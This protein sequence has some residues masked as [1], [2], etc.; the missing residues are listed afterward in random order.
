[1]KKRLLAAAVLLVA[2]GIAIAAWLHF[3]GNED[4]N[5]LEL[6]GNVD[7][8]QVSLAFDATGRI[9]QMNAQEGDRVTAG[10]VLGRLDTTTLALQAR[11][12]EARIE[13]QRQSTLRLR[14]GARPEEIAQARARLAAAE[15]DAAR[16]S[17]EAARLQDVAARTSSRGVS[18]QELEAART[19]ARTA[20]ARAQEQREA[21]RLLEVGSRSEDVGAAE[22]QLRGLRAELDLLRHQ[23]AQGELRAPVS[24]VVRSRLM[25][26]GDLAS[27]Q[28]PA[29]AIALT[30]PKWVRVYVNETK[31]G[32]VKPGAPAQVVTDSQPQRPIAGKV[33]YISSVAEFTPKSVQTQE[34]RTTLVYEVRVRVDD[35]DNVLRLG[36]PATVRLDVRPAEPAR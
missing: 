27:P 31:L 36:Q 29:Y 23:M 17:D 20:A 7:I 13:A 28:K 3:R 21:L 6:Q 8:R 10:Q 11:Q 19:A 16:T 5:H 32:K 18:A 22:A 34:V 15:A 35:P 26:P 14:N 30:D 33:A 25:E 4:P 9:E 12:A 1:M 2:I 24:G